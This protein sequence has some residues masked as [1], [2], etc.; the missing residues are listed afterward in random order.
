M[1]KKTGLGLLAAAAAAGAAA[2]VVKYLKDYTDFKTD[3]ARDFHDLEGTT[4]EV[5]D[6]AKR[7][8][9]SIKEHADVKSAA[10]DLA[11]AAG[12]VAKDAGSI[13]KKAGQTT[14][15]AVKEIKVRYQEDP[16]GTKEGLLDSMRE[17]G[18]DV[19]QKISDVT[20]EVSE[21]L[22]PEKGFKTVVED[23]TET[24]ADAAKDA[25]EAVQEAA[26]N[27]KDAAADTLEDAKEAGKD[28]AEDAAKTASEAKDAVKEKAADAK[29]AVADVAEKAADTADEIKEAAAGTEDKKEADNQ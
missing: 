13:A 9:I 26:E 23:V 17:L 28:L 27:A 7:T 21:R 4:E 2:V 14:V 19:T 15:L 29:E 18:A 8:Y 3:A 22:K 16:E 1:G 11:K 6:A 12:G 20:A 10:G 24:A 25:K 5:K